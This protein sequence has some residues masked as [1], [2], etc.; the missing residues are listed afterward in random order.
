MIP[1]KPAGYN[2]LSPYFIVKDAPKFVQLL[3]DL[4]DAIELRRYEMPDGRI[5]HLEMKLDDSVV[6]ISEATAEY[7]ANEF[8]LHFY[9]KDAR[10]IYKKALDLGCEGLQEPVQKNDPDLRG[11]F[12]DFSG[13]VWSIGTQME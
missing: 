10:A 4:F 11:M 9:V 2:S 6:M 12:R 8:L 13:N 3:T 1:F 5:M 7:P